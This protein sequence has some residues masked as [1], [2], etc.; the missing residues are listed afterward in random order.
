MRGENMKL[1]LRILGISIFVG[2]LYIF[3][4]A[5]NGYRGELLINGGLK[6]F[7]QHL[8]N[9]FDSLLETIIEKTK[10]TLLEF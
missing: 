5:D 8:N 10:N 4:V 1:G 2:L 3:F 9:M 6:F 7:G